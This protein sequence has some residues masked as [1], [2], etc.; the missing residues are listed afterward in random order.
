[1][2]IKKVGESSPWGQIDHVQPVV[3]GA[4]V[5]DTP[6]HGGLFLS[7]DFPRAERS[8][9]PAPWCNTLWFEEDCEMYVPVFFIPRLRAWFIEKCQVNNGWSPEESAAKLRAIV[10]R[11]Y[12]ELLAEVAAVDAGNA[13]RA[14]LA[15]SAAA[16]L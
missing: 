8:R 15:A 7:P 3:E 5:V 4:V 11:W 9:L 13:A 16:L 10:L 6:G 2:R 12:P 14:V 1:M